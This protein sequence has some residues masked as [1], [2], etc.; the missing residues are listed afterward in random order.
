M[1]PNPDHA[2]WLAA[3]TDALL[4]G[5]PPRQ[6]PATLVPRVMAAIQTRAALPWY[7]ESWQMWPLPLRIGSLAVLVGC[8]GGLCLAGGQLPQAAAQAAAALQLSHWFLGA[9]ALWDVLVVLSQAAVSVG[10]HLPGGFAVACLVALGL[11]YATCVG[12]GAAWLRFTFA[13]RGHEII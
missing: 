10:K 8:F 4:K 13:R 2:R 3:Q 9:R 12:L 1:N 11:G 5:L 6:A 7:R